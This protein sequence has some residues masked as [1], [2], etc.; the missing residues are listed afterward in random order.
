[1]FKV[2]SRT[3]EAAL[4]V[5]DAVVIQHPSFGLSPK[6]SGHQVPSS[7]RSWPAEAASFTFT[8]AALDEAS[9]GAVGCPG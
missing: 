6:Y 1:V 9:E 3:C 8:G 4:V 5:T 2:Q 7:C